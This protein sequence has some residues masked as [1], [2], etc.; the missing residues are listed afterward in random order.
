MFC[1]GVYEH[2]DGTDAS[3]CSIADF[4]G[5]QHTVHEQGAVISRVV[6]RDVQKSLQDR[7]QYGVWPTW[8]TLLNI[9]RVDVFRGIGGHE[10]RDQPHRHHP[11]SLSAST[12][13]T[14]V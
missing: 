5:F 12:A 10:E 7:P 8:K 1:P 14:P 6:D 9:P 11:V 13:S 2:W 4:G 3:A